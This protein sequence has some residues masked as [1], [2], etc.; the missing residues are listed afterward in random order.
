MRM[1]VKRPASRATAL[2]NREML[3]AVTSAWRREISRDGPVARRRARVGEAGGRKKSVAQHEVLDMKNPNLR[4]VTFS[5]G[6]ERAR[7]RRESGGRCKAQVKLLGQFP[8]TAARI[9]GP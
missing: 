4:K 8:E 1:K 3:G 9:G 5:S 2:Q 6:E 7:V